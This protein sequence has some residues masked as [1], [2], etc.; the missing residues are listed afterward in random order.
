MLHCGTCYEGYIFMKKA[1]I[2]FYQVMTKLRYLLCVLFLFAIGCGSEEDNR[3]VI[4]IT[5]DTLRAD[6]LGC[7]GY[8]RDT[9]PFLD[10]VA[11]EGILF[12]NAIA[13]WPKT[14][15]SMASML[16][17]TY[18]SSNTTI[19]MFLDGLPD[20][21]A[22]V[23]EILQ[24]KRYQTLGVT[25]NPQLGKR[26]RF[27]RGFDR[28]IESWMEGYYRK[29]GSHDFKSTPGYVKLFTNA[30][31][32]TDQAIGLL[33]SSS[34]RRNF[35]LWLHYM[36]THGPYFSPTFYERYF[37]DW[38]RGTPVALNDIPPYQRRYIPGTKEIERDPEYYKVQYD[39]EI[40]YWDDEL[41][42]LFSYLKK[43]GRLENTIVVITADHGESLDEHG[44]YFEHG[45]LPYQPASHVPLIMIAPQ[46][47]NMAGRIVNKPVSLIDLI[48]TLF[49]LMGI[50][51]SETFEGRS[52][53]PLI[54]N[55]EPHHP[56]PILSMAGENQPW[57]RII[58]V[59]D[60]KLIHIRSEKDRHFMTGK[61]YEL[62]NVTDD[63]DEQHNLV[64]SLPQ[65]AESLQDMFPDWF[66]KDSGSKIKAEK[67]VEYD[68]FSKEMLKSLGYLK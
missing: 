66:A 33:E 40:R 11:K 23:S 67:K 24:N 10:E 48:P 3:N 41:K 51:Q 19:Q 52:L 42:R 46:L 34:A 13:S 39:R 50:S 30:T 26:Q 64:D 16:T 32:V 49:D 54:H 47:G 38:E 14:Q 20:D 37:S 62:Y 29:T 35:F 58:R 7:Y 27:D 63:P 6:H 68:E 55:E 36:D 17:S 65:R 60:W 61:D 45:K 56:R 15:P 53:M 18:P 1:V 22:L 4:L 59:G 12:Q 44:Y 25:S 57:Q 9:S 8:F 2:T 21:I 43:K 28:F 5:V 31:I